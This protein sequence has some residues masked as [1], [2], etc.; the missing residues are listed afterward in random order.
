MM[1]LQLAAQLFTYKK[2]LAVL[3]S[4]IMITMETKTFWSTM[5]TVLQNYTATMGMRVTGFL[6]N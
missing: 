5:E 3:L 4:V 6:W 2:C 1:H